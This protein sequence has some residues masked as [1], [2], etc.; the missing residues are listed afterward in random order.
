MSENLAVQTERV[1]DIPILLAMTKQMGIAEL[2]NALFGEHGNRQGISLGE[3]L[4]GWLTY[5]LSEGDHRLN[6][7]EEWAEKREE[8]LRRSLNEEVRA[9]D[10]ADDRLADG[11]GQLSRDEKWSALERALNERSIRVYELGVECVRIDSTTGS[12]YWEVTEE[13]LFQFGHSKDHRP[14]LPQVKVMLSTLDPMGMPVVTQVV[15]GERADDKLYIPAIDEVRVGL[16]Q[17]GLLYV[18]DCKMMALETRAHLQ[19]GQDYYLGPFSLTHVSRE[20]LDEYLKPVWDEKQALTVVYRESVD[21]QEKPIAEGFEQRETL[22]AEVDEE[23][24]VWAERRLI[25]RSRAHAKS[26][27]TALKK[28][29]QQAQTDI[30]ALNEHK[31]GK[32]RFVDIASL[33]QAAET[34]LKKH[35][36]D[37]LLVL[38]YSEQVQEH[39]VRKHKE[40]PA[41]IRIERQVRVAV[42]HDVT[43]IGEAIRRLGWRV[44]GTNSPSS[45][46]PLDKA[47]L[48]Y[49]DEYLVEHC[50]GRLKGKPLG[51]TPMYLADDQRA[52]GLIRLLSIG[53]RVLTL[54]EHV[55]RRRLAQMDQSLAGL[56]AGNPTRATRRPTTEALL[57]AFKDI[58]LSFVSV[59][60]QSYCYLSPLSELQLK[61]LDL[62]GLPDTI[63][64]SL[65]ARSSHSPNPP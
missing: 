12:G 45:L 7:V 63:Y 10:F 26:A 65:S 11:L 8:T 1:D 51:L 61:I 21:G 25:I 58:F 5:I 3:M 55:V 6:Q 57:R 43:A 42:Q 44:Y 32:T 20:T 33:Q 52:T 48:A 4:E 49:R 35:Q 13:G 41:E 56:Y 31:Q 64:S 46:L 62:L 16:G 40:R 23:M 9:L 19:A 28:R 34:L 17:R 36:V 30:E 54:L 2:V 37:G 22:T 50:F 60:N 14:N 47:V 59:G 15:S 38:T 53:V 18:G 39:L 27:E 29:L 24:Q